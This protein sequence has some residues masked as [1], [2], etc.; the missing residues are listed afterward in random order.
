MAQ[1]PLLDRIRGFWVRHRTLFWTLHTAWALATGL[2][3]AIFARERYELVLWVVLF[4]ALTW[5]STLFFGRGA[6][7]TSLAEDGEARDATGPPGLVHEVTSYLTRIMYQETL[8]FLLPFYFYSTVVRSPNVGFIVLL[9]A[10][11][12][13]SCIDLLFDRWLRTHAAFALA[14]FTVVAFAA[15]NLLLP[16]LFGLGPRTATPSAAL[17]AIAGTVPL[18][19]RVAPRTA[20]VRVALG[21]VV[22]AIL[23]VAIGFPNLVPPVPIRLEHATFSSDIDSETLEITDTLPSRASTTEVG[24]SLVV[25][26]EVFAPSA[27]PARVSLEWMRDGE[28]L[29]VSREI[30]IVAYATGFRVWDRWRSPSGQVPPGRY[31]V[32]LRA[33]GDRFFGVA[34]QRVVRGSD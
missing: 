11:A 7:E 19:L 16:L 26:V 14:F 25:L 18:T 28:T 2:A 8:F 24:S 12:I 20:R 9:G 4:L 33:E 21:L 22:A 31:E 3:V 30:E 23:V 29:R 32:V 6:V 10:L 27:V 15:L 34:S 13:L 1:A 17:A 5:S